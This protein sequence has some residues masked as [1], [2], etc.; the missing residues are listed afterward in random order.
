MRPIKQAGTEQRS[1]ANENKEVHRAQRTQ[2]RL[3][4]WQLLAVKATHTGKN[5]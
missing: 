3:S 4:K 2:N 1:S 5:L